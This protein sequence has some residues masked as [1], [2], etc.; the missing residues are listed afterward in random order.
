MKAKATSALLV[1]FPA[2]PLVLADHEVQRFEVEISKLQAPVLNGRQPT[3]L[4][5]NYQSSTLTMLI[6]TMIQVRAP[7]RGA[8]GQ[9]PR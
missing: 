3:S 6:P 5:T 4:L 7:V 2:E 1:V 9:R 8:Q